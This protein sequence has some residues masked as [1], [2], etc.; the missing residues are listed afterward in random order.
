MSD[1]LAGPLHRPLLRLALPM[2]AGYVFQMGFNYVDTFLVG[3]LGPEALAAVGGSMFVVW[4]LF[5]F[6]EVV[7]VGVLARVARA[8]GAGRGDEVGAALAGGALVGLGLTAVVVAAVPLGAVEG[9]VAAMGIEAGV[10]ALA[11]DYL[12]ILFL[13]FPALLAFCLL[14]SVFRGAGDARTPMLAVSCAF[15][16]NAVLDVVLIFGLGPIPALGVAGAALASVTARAVGVAL[17]AAALV[18]RR[19]ALGL[20]RPAPGWQAPARLLG[21]VR[22]GA[23]SS[24]AGLSFCL[25]YLGLVRI[26]AGF[27]TAAVAALGLGIRLEGLAYFALIA[28][29]R[30]AGVMAGQ[31]LGA[32]QPERAWAAVRR[33]EALGYLAMVPATAALLLVPEPL[34]ILFSD[35]PAVVEA[36][37]LYLRIVALALFPYVKEIVLDNVA[38]GVG[39]TVPAMVVEGLGTLLRLPIA[40]ALAALGL[41]YA[42]VWWSVAATM[43]LKAAAF[44]VWF[45]R[46]TWAERTLD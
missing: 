23:P 21:L 5:A 3:G 45:R 17:L 38:A 29:G 46:G 28:L 13:G 30:A 39:D 16:L 7:S 2:F 11:T 15:L 31:N 14:E 18:L 20:G 43:L 10:A 19:R 44:E 27:G 32:A 22:I 9:L 34:V 8:A 12:R 37:S 35:D 36:A 42:A 33:A 6:A 4:A 24:A 41:G 40:L 26:T 25:I 1:V